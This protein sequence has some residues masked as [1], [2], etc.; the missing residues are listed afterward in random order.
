MAPANDFGYTCQK[1]EESLDFIEN[2]NIRTVKI[3][4]GI[5]VRKNEGFLSKLVRFLKK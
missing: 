4:N 2:L 3:R 5:G 1:W